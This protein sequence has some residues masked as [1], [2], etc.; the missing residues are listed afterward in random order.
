MGCRRL[1]FPRK[2]CH[3][4]HQADRRP[5]ERN[6]ADL[7]WRHLDKPDGAADFTIARKAPEKILATMQP[8]Y[9]ADYVLPKV[10]LRTVMLDGSP[11]PSPKGGDTW[12]VA[13]DLKSFSTDGAAP[14]EVWL[15]YQHLVPT[16]RTGC[17]C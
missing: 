6:T 14:G 9:D 4:L 3:E 12:R 7:A 10:L 5:A 1:S 8:V 17:A 11:K 2:S 16:Y 15:S 13:E